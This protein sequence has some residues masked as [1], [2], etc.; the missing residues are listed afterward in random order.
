VAKK[1]ID[2][3]KDIHKKSLS[4]ND[5]FYANISVDVISFIDTLLKQTE[6][7]IFSGIIRDY[8]VNS[9][10][11]KF[12]DIDIII[13][14]NLRIEE[15]FVNINYQK[16]SFGGYKIQIDNFTIDL[17]VIKKTWALNNGQLKFEFDFINQLPKTTFFNFSSVLYSLNDK[18]FIIGVD[19]LRFIR[20]KKIEIVSDKNP[21]PELCIVNSFYYQDKLK[22]KLGDKLKNY[23]K[24]NFHS[25]LDRLES[26]QLKHF[27]EI[28]Y[29]SDTLKS[30]YD[31]LTEVSR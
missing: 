11:K 22:L 13:E 12:R 16:N 10:S 3:E 5:Y 6:V 9:E 27:K 7:F 14:E 4:F 23:I 19:F 29:T 21:L 20:D 1:L 8:F 26:V 31:K 30:R 18:K 2:I 25:Q 15:M 24:N 28:K 17:W